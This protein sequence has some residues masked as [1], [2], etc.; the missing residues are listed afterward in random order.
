[1][2][3]TRS[4][5]AVTCMAVVSACSTV[6]A[7]SHSGFLSGYSALSGGHDGF[8]GMRSTA[9]IDP[10]RV[11]IGDIEWCAPMSTSVTDDERHLLMRQLSDELAA[12]VRG[13][14]AAPNGRPAV[15]RAAITRVET[16]SPGLNVLSAALLVVPLDRG[17]ASVEIEALDPNTGEQLAALTLSHFAPLSELKSHFYRLA[18]AQLALRKAAADFSALLRP[19]V[20]MVGFMTKSTVPAGSRQR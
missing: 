18:P 2:N 9:A 17:G 5:L 13:I 10:T 8:A 15:V 20:E 12:S 4:F 1:M 16:V 11:T 3:A 19:T 14:P 7:P 6:M